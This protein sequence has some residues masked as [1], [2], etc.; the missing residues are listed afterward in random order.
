MRALL[1][2]FRQ[3]LPRLWHC[4]RVGLTVIWLLL[5]RVFNVT[6]VKRS[7]VVVK[8]GLPINLYSFFI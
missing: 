6:K 3:H 1:H 7:S 5:E 4:E 8:K 2:L